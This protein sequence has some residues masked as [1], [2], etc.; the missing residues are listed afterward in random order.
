MI[1]KIFRD[2]K[3]FLLGKK[4]YTF[5]FQTLTFGDS[6]LSLWFFFITLFGVKSIRKSRE[7]FLD[8][9]DK[10]FNFKKGFLFG[11][12]RSSLFA[13]L[14][15]LNFDKGSEILITGFTC[16]VVPNA[17]IN[18]GYTP[19]Y[20]DINPVNY[21]MD[22]TIAEKLIT[23][24]TKV[25]IIQHTFGIPAQ[26]EELINIA[27]KYNLYIIEDCAVSLGS[28]YKGKLT[29]TF[30]DAS[31]F[32]FELSKTIT[33]CNGGMLLLNTNNKNIIEKIE[34]FYKKVPEQKRHQNLKKLFQLGISGILYRPGTYSLGKYIIALF[35]KLKMF[36]FST[37][38]TEETA[39]LPPNY[40]L[41]LSEYQTRII[42]RQYLRIN[43]SIEKKLILKNYYLKILEKHINKEFI[44]I[45]SLDDVVLLRFPFLTNKRISLKSY[46]ESINVELGLWFTAPLSSKTINHS[47]F[48]YKWG[49]CPQAE[50]ISKMIVNLPVSLS[51]KEVEKMKLK[52]IVNNI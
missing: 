9:V 1:K 47:L 35:F 37:T 21:C 4:Q 5:Y 14:K 39:K 41:R 11:S 22:P 19:I 40:L 23:K 48:G 18:T 29:G 42:L 31:I 12:A 15:T 7:L 16:E 25:I 38:K 10:L 30:G 33:S 50:K 6:L 51:F 44:K 43:N 2:I 20:V 45:I 8:E 26:I 36:S 28:K 3:S 46:F 17:V 24:K 49:C 27:K 34:E 13:L 52:K 32:S